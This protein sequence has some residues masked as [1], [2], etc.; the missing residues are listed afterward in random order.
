MAEEKTKNRWLE[1]VLNLIELTQEGKLKWTADASASTPND[2]DRLTAVFLTHFKDKTLRLYGIRVPNEEHRY[3]VMIGAARD[4]DLP[5]WRMKIVL[6]FVNSDGF[7]LWTFPEIA[8]LYDLL[9]AVQYQVAGV[10]DFLNDI[11][12]ETEALTG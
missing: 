3:M 12:S 2:D 5:K 7:A 10:A 9:A 4:K 1:A 11:T 8:A 6:E